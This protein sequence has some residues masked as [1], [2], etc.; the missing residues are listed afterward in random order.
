M[1]SELFD[2]SLAELNQATGRS[3]SGSGIKGKEFVGSPTTRRRISEA[4]NKD[5]RPLPVASPMSIGA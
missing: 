5:K 4:P 1:T 2:R 3:L